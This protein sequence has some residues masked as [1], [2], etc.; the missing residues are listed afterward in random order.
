MPI[1]RTKCCRRALLALGLLATTY[2]HA[3]TICTTIAT[4]TVFGV[5]DTLYASPVLINST[6]TV[7]CT[8][9][10]AALNPIPY[11][12][13]LSTSGTSNTMA[14]AMAGP[15]GSLLQYNLFTSASY[16]TVWGNGTAG[17]QTVA[18]SVTPLSLASLVQ[19]NH[20]VYGRIPALQTV[21]V[22]VYLDSITVTVDY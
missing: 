21:R 13:S 6:I 4:P 5:Y 17:T 10:L 16:A 2:S 19:Q 15:L 22:G 18:G 9:T 12:I 11:T 14:R 1:T 7:A 3:I 8:V 20:T